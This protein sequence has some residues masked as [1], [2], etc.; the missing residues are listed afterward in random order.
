[1]HLERERA[2]CRLLSGLGRSF[3]AL[4]CTLHYKDVISSSRV[5]L[6]VVL[7]LVLVL[8]PPGSKA[9]ANPFLGCVGI[10]IDTMLTALV[11]LCT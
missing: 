4:E 6:S 11:P 2:A 9:A 1:M 10:E 8:V 3:M 7:V 5:V